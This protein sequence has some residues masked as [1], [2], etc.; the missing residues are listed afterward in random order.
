MSDDFFKDNKR[1]IEAYSKWLDEVI[2]D[3]GVSSTEERQ[4]PKIGVSKGHCIKA[5]LISNFLNE[6]IDNNY[7]CFIPFA[8]KNLRKSFLPIM[9]DG[10]RGKNKERVEVDID[11]I[12]NFLGQAAQEIQLRQEDGT[13]V[14]APVSEIL[15][16]FFIQHI[17]Q[18]LK[19]GYPFF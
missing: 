3:E 18:M 15:N 7:G 9:D 5:K 2:I 4:L 17:E 10:D 12:I 13:I 11:T 6:S 16:Y 1:N 19:K 8:L 14:D